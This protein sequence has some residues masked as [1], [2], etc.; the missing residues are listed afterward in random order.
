[1][2]HFWRR[3]YGLFRSRVQLWKEDLFRQPMKQQE[4]GH[5][6]TTTLYTRSEDGKGWTKKKLK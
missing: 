6:P 3:L 1:M 4:T 5:K 2:K